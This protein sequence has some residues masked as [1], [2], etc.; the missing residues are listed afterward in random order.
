MDWLLHL[1]RFRQYAYPLP[2]PTVWEDIKI[3]VPLELENPKTMIISDDREEERIIGNDEGVELMSTNDDTK[4][5]EDP[6][7]TPY[8]NICSQV[9]HVDPPSSRFKSRMTSFL[10]SS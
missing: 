7:D 1:R 4:V 5:E 6:D 2:L 8:T 3:E 9:T 10:G